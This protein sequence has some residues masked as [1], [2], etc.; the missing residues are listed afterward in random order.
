VA[1]IYTAA[2][3][4]GLK[5]ITVYRDGCRSGVLINNKDLESNKPPLKR[6][7][8]LPCDVYHISVKGQ[9][10]F[11]FVGL[12]N[13]R[14]YEVFAGKNGVIDRKIKS[15]NV[16]KYRQKQY[17]VIFDDESELCPITAFT[18][19]EEDIVTRL[20]S[21]NLRNNVDM[22]LVVDQLRKAKGDMTTFAKSIAKALAKYIP[23]GT[24]LDDICEH[25]NLPL[26]HEGGCAICFSCGF[27]KCY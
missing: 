4:A 21:A 13:E 26:R 24:E 6:P 27:S 1:T 7:K 20:I 22:Q 23:D 8:S 9:P 11:V 19:D 3:K 16:I 2:W 25:C 12:Y 14:P 15:G 17:K 10:Y 18:T 5:G